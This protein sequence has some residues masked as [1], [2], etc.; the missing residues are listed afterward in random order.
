MQQK[1]CYRNIKWTFEDLLPCYCY[2]IKTNSRTIRSRLSQPTSA[3][4]GGYMSELQARADGGHNSP[5]AGSL[6]G[7]RITAG[8]AK[9][10]LG[11]PKIP[12]NFTITFFITVNFLLKDLTFEHGGAKLASCTGRSLTSLRPCC[13]L[14]T[15]WHY[16]CEPDSCAV[17][18]SFR[19]KKRPLQES[20]QLIGIKLPTSGFSRN[21]WFVIPI[22]RG[23]MPL[24]PPLRTPM[25]SL[26][27]L[28]QV[29][30]T[31]PAHLRKRNVFD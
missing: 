3:G 5:G 4:E 8:D 30:Q 24:L 28:Y 21:I 18:V 2:A 7:R 10:L 1:T 6:W 23:E 15:A 9:C 19:Q 12:N 22:S 11:P 13:K 27:S 16:I 20:N 17:W 31:K 29:P 14:I 25:P 26:T